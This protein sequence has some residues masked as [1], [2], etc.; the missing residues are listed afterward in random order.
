MPEVKLAVRHQATDLPDQLV[1]EFIGSI[2]VD[3]TAE[4]ERL[5]ILP[6]AC[7]KV[8]LNFAQLQRVNSMGLAQLL[9]LFE[10]WQA[11]QVEIK[12][13]N[14]NRMIGVLFKMTGLASYLVG[15]AGSS[16][17]SPVTTAPVSD[18]PANSAP[19]PQ[20]ADSSHSSSTRQAPE[21]PQVAAVAQ[22]IVS[23]ESQPQPVQQ[24]ES[25]R[26]AL[27][28]RQSV[29]KLKFWVSVQSSQQMHG[30]YFFNTYLQR[31]LGRD[32]HMELIHGPFNDSHLQDAEMDI[33]FSKPFEATR[34]ILQQQFLPIM[35][36]SEQSDEVTLLARADDARLSLRAY[37]GGKVVTASQ[38]NFVY[39]LGRFLLE[40]DEAALADMDYQFVGCDIKGLLSVIRGNAD[41]LLLLSDSY[42]GLSSLTKS[43]L[44]VIDQS[45]TQFAFHLLALA[46]HCREL[47]P[48]LEGLLLDMSQNSQGR[49][50][51]AD[52]GMSGWSKPTDDEI[53]MLAML[54]NRYSH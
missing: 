40:E 46:P 43:K 50:V 41:I 14:A 52:L 51:L 11:Q 19:R 13:A 48:M 7:R 47:A 17:A 42:Q 29:G 20:L 23:R 5:Q 18:G 53:N 10:H 54:Y 22:K 15:N 24:P 31:H 39:L 26:Q 8:L 1:L 9:K 16:P 44:R 12:I 45:E 3:A 34:L 32:I 21:P 35:R 30:W 49:Q 25:A 38:A 4:L 28:R 37:Q 27:L 2:D 36:P 33:V 6:A